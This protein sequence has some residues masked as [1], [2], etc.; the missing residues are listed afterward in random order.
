M[1]AIEEEMSQK[2]HSQRFR[3]FF[4][5]CRLAQADLNELIDFIE[6]VWLSTGIGEFN[7]SQES[8]V[9][10]CGHVSFIKSNIA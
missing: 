2:G 3:P 7:K 8:L 1:D 4:E 6:N 9:D 5:S 10:K